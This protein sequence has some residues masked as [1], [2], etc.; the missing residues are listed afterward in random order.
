MELVLEKFTSQDF[1]SYFR[2]VGDS[3]V[4][5]MITERAIPLHEAKCDYEKLLTRNNIHPELGQFKIHAGG[6]FVGLA[7]LEVLEEKST[8]AEVGYMILPE[9]WGQ[10][11]AGRVASLLVEKAQTQPRLQSLFAIIDPANLPSKKVLLNNQFTSREFRDFDGL[12][13]E[14]LERVW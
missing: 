8:T 6:H 3:R 5:A 12:P 4:M 2:L 11:I 14:V 10:G 7:K 13:G 1:E 9:Y